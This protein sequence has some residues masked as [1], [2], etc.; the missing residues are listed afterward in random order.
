MSWKMSQK[1]VKNESKIEPN[2][3]WV[4]K[5]WVKKLS[6]K[7]IKSKNMSQTWVKNWVKSILGGIYGCCDQQI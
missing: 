1:W 4:K 5:K 2:N 6:Q 3:S 7:K